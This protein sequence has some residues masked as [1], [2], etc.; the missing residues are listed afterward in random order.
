[1]P[2]LAE[3]V[4][5]A[6]RERV[7]ELEALVRRAV[8]VELERVTAELV[9]RE[10]EQRRNGE[11]DVV[12]ERPAEL[13]APAPRTCRECGA[14]PALEGRAIGRRCKSRR[15]R[16]RRARARGN[17]PRANGSDE[18]PEPAPRR[19]STAR[20]GLIGERELDRREQRRRLLAE[21]EVELVERDGREYRLVRLPAPEA[22]ALEAR[23]RVEPRRRAGVA[24][25]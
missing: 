10:L 7:V 5:A 3:L 21:A 11:H 4:A 19:L 18:E 1:V 20:F 17:R 8:D 23:V 13:E 25:A 22:P 12:D 15:D 14:E 6:V 9:E 16:E 2:Q 24:I